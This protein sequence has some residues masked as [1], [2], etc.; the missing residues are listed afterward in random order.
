[1]SRHVHKTYDLAVIGGGSAGLTAAGFAAQL[2]RKVAIV[3]RN[4]IGGDCTWTGC[5][6]SKVLL[7][8]ARTAHETRQAHRFG[9]TSA[10]PEVDLS[11]VMAH[12]RSVIEQIYQAES[13]EALQ[14]R[15]ID[16]YLA[17][18]KFTDSHTLSAGDTTIKAKRI[19][20]ATGARPFIPPIPGLDGVEYLTYETVWELEKLPRRL[21]VV[22]G[23][24]IGCELAQAFQRLGSHV[25]L[26]EAAERILLHDEPEAADLLA[27]VL[28]G[29]GIDLRLGAPVESVWQD[30]TGIHLTAGGQEVAGDSLLLAVGRRPNVNDMDLERAGVSYNSGGIAVNAHLRTSQRHI[31]AAGDCT[32]GFQFTHYAGW[33]GFMAARNALLPGNA[34]AVLDLAP[35]AT[36]TDPEI[37]HAGLTEAQARQ[38]YGN[39]IEVATWPMDKVDRAITEGDEIGAI[40][41]VCRPNGKLLGAT[42]VNARAGEMIHQ[43][44]LAIDQGLKLGDL[45]DSLHIYPTYSM[46]GMQLASQERLSQLLAGTSGKIIR[47]LSRLGR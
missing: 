39:R 6:P 43:W 41:V 4:R 12:V 32:G 11:S 35:W 27:Q 18:V 26:V 36:F 19:L 33:Q 3:E 10:E 22:G 28:T 20:I 25:T 5:V 44:I 30:A 14:T 24:P 9:I 8:V 46:A 29:E 38:R 40:K 17:P 42:M 21:L 31:Y 16:T 45:A 7:R 34:R 1:M 13:P 47:A 2:G 23:G 15:G 37:A